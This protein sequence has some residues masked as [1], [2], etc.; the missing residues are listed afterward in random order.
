MT[1]RFACGGEE[2]AEV[3]FP[4]DGET[5]RPVTGYSVAS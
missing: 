1:M 4:G 3:S 5:S 2:E